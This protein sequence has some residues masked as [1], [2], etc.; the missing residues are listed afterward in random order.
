MRGKARGDRGLQKSTLVHFSWPAGTAH[1]SC[2]P[3]GDC[4]GEVDNIAEDA[5]VHKGKGTPG[6]ATLFSVCR[7]NYR[8]SEPM[9]PQS[10]TLQ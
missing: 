7:S 3:E 6:I 2:S 10:A 1:F 9:L 5:I 4:T 8:A